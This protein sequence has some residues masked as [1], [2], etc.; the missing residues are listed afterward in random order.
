MRQPI[1][2]AF[3]TGGAILSGPSY[4]NEIGTNGVYD[5]L[6]GYM[7]TSHI[8]VNDWNIAAETK[9][10][11]KFL[12]HPDFPTHRQF[13]L[14][15][16][17]ALRFL[18][19]S[20]SSARRERTIVRQFLDDFYASNSTA[21][22]A[23]VQKSRARIKRDSQE[24]LRLLS[25]AMGYR[26]KKKIV[27]EAFPTILPFSPFGT[28]RFYFSILSELVGK[29]S[30]DV[31]MI[32]LHEISHFIFFDYLKKIERSGKFMLQPDARHYVKE[33]LTAALFN[34]E[35]MKS[36]LGLAEYA[37]NP[38]IRNLYLKSG[39]GN[40]VRITDWIRKRYR[41]YMPIST[42]SFAELLTELID[43][44]RR[45]QSE[46]KKKRKFWNMHGKNIFSSEMLKKQYEQTIDL[47]P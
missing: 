18:L 37:G 11:L 29:R 47:S 17:P 14:D 46:F 42:E 35:P 41:T 30:Q 6:V 36:F 4:G 15:A 8:V 34:E 33:A 26:W 40:S 43:A 22:S 1:R 23:A 27:Y 3:T 45:K 28:N 32:A 25:A 44:V 38:E 31:L 10:F 7:N 13:I 39:A 19:N 12:R 9:I 24:G 21:I 16:F 2:S 20:I 5:N